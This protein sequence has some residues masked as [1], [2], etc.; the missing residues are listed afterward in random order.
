MSGWCVR[1]FADGFNLDDKS[2]V[3]LWINTQRDLY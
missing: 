1:E 2:A 3:F